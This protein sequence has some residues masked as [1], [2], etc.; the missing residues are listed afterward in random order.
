MKAL[1]VVCLMALN[2]WPLRRQ[3]GDSG[4]VTDRPDIT[5]SAIV[6]P[7]ASIQFENDLTWTAMHGAETVDLS[8]S[9]VR[10]GFFAERK[11][12]SELR[13]LAAHFPGKANQASGISPLVSS[14]RS[15]RS[16]AAW[17]CP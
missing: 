3:S 5:E 13:T 12:G 8:E 6:V 1:A 17:I 7:V 10:L 4:I 15:G 9:L 2:P 16:Q 14:N 11:C